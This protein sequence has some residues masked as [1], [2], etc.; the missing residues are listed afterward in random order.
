MPRFAIVVLM[1]TCLGTSQARAADAYADVVREYLTGDPDAAIAR[2][3]TL[4]FGK[5]VDHNVVLSAE[6]L[7]SRRMLAGAA[8]LHTEAALRRALA[9]SIDW[10]QLQVATALVEAGEKGTL[11][12]SRGLGSNSPYVASPAAA[13]TVGDDFRLLWYRVVVAALQYQARTQ[14]SD[15]YLKHA[16]L[17]SPGNPDIQVLAGIGQEMRCA[18]RVA[19]I[20]SCNVRGA[21]AAAEP[22]FRAALEAQPDRLEARLR[23]GRVLQQLDRL[24]EA[25][26]V[27]APLAAAADDRIAY[28]GQVFLGGVEDAL[29]H[30]EAALAAYDA[31]A[32]RLPRAQTARLSASEVR[33]RLGER[34]AATEAIPP[35]TGEANALEPWWTYT[36]GEYWRIDVLLDAVRRTRMP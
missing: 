5:I 25:R 4:D 26:A 19:G 13:A 32:A 22:H 6:I 2:V 8:A 9:G 33:Y 20:K 29:Q 23:L 28:L 24:Q 21:L 12:E 27:L 3:L 34:Q 7:E 31:A 11:A 16:L 1:A 17:L 30:P 14:Q 10:F 35:A 18:P 36:F 15:A